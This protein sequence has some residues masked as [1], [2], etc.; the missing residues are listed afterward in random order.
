MPKSG[1]F[2]YRAKI[3]IGTMKEG[4]NVYSLSFKDSSGKKSLKESL[5]IEYVKDPTVREARRL[6]LASAEKTAVQAEANS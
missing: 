2:Y 6:E 4:K 5:T 1:K 3:S